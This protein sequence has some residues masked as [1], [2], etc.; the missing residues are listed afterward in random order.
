MRTK[1]KWPVKELMDK[2]Q[3]RLL[4]GW[5]R[6]VENLNETEEMV[7]VCEPETGR[8]ISDAE[9]K[10]GS[11][12][13]LIGCQ[14]GSPEIPNCQE[15]KELRLLWNLTDCQEDSQGISHCQEDNEMRS[16]QDLIVCQEGSRKIP[17]FQKGMGEKMRLYENLIDL[18][19]SSYQRGMPIDA[20]SCGLTDHVNEDDDK[21]KTCTIQ[22]EDRRNLLM[23]G[24]IGIFFPFSQDEAK[25]C[26]SNDA[27]REG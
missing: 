17:I 27:G 11:V 15:G 16:L 2:R 3:Q 13:N 6:H 12:E 24:G 1:S 5:L 10:M 19:V 25:F 14:E 22:K 23:I 8:N 9:D 18:K 21:L 4:S 7:Q 20:D 26:V